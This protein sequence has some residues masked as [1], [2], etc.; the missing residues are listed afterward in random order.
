VLLASRHALFCVL[1]RLC[2][3]IPKP[4]HPWVRAVVVSMACYMCVVLG[5]ILGAPCPERMGCRLHRTGELRRQA[6][7]YRRTC[8]RGLSWAQGCARTVTVQLSK[9][10]TSHKYTTNARCS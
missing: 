10:F 9:S 4:V 1:D 7:A 6:A 3:A 2:H 8:T 5:G